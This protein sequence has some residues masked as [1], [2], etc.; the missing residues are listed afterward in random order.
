M[1]LAVMQPYIFPYLGYFQ[2]IAAADVFV[3]Y[4]TVDYMQ[5]GWVNRNRI[6]MHGSAKYFTVSVQKSALGTPIHQVL[7]KDYDSWSDSFLN[8]IRNAYLKAPHFKALYELLTEFV[9]SKK[10]THI[11]ALAQES[12][13]IICNHLGIATT[14]VSAQELSIPQALNRQERLEFLI[15]SYKAQR[16]VLPPGS[17]ELYQ[18]WNPDCEKAILAMPEFTYT[19]HVSEFVPFLSILD[20]MA[21]VDLETI[22]HQIHSPK[23]Q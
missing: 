23:W 20:T 6:L 22:K 5:R 11:G 15:T 14:I 21:Y 13:K 3:S 17:K 16:M 1:N 10:H 18:D 7:I 19:Q 2:M 4:D 12:L 8:S 9:L